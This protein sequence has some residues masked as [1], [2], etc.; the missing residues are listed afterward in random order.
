VLNDWRH[1]GIGQRERNLGLL[2]PP[3][4]HPMIVSPIDAKNQTRRIDFEP[5]GDDRPNDV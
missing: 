2:K 5:L 4:E 1:F 3:A